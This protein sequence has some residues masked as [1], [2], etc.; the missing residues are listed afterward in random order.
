MEGNN[1]GLNGGFDGWVEVVMCLVGQAGRAYRELHASKAAL[2][3]QKK[4]AKQM[5][6]HGLRKGLANKTHWL[7]GKHVCLYYGANSHVIK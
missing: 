1:F 2:P 6:K 3:I 4:A 7:V 5:A